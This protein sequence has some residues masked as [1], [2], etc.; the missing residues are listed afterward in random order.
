M[1]NDEMKRWI[2]AASYHELLRK[3]RFADVGEEWFMGDVG[4]Y[5]S[6]IMGKRREEIGHDAAVAASKSVGWIPIK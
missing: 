2:D 3:W 4:A 6:T 5:F 1:T